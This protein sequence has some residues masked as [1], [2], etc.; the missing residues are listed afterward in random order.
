[1]EKVWVLVDRAGER[2]APLSLELLTKS[3]DLAARVEGVTWGDGAE[4]AAEAGAYGAQVLHTV[5]DV[6]GGLPGPAVAAAMAARIQAGEGPDAVLVPHNY[7][8]R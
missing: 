5:G 7:D 4:L 8:G 1:M 6:G 2:V 3:K